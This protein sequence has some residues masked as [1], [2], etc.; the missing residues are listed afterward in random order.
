MHPNSISTNR[1][2]DPT[3]RLKKKKKTL[4]RYCEAHRGVSRVNFAFCT[5][6]AK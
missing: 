2:I 5:H 4:Y 6:H 3:T 1:I